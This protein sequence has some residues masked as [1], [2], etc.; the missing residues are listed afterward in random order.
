MGKHMKV[1]FDVD[2]PFAWAHGGVQVLV[3]ELM[4]HL[5]MVGVEVEPLKWWDPKQ[6]AD[7]INLFYH[8]DQKLIFAKEKGI[9]IANYVFLDNY[10]S[11]SR[12]DLYFR[13]KMIALLK[14]S[15]GNIDSVKGFSMKKYSDGFIFPSSNDKMLSHYLFGTDINKSFVILH[16]VADKYFCNSIQNPNKSDYLICISTIHKR[17]NSVMLAEIALSLKIPIYFLGR[18]YN[19]ED[20]Y[21]KRF[22]SIV[23]NKYVVYKG[24]VDE[25][26]K[27]K[28]M[29]NSKGFI[30]LS[31]SE[32]GCIAVLEA[33]AIKLPVFLPNYSWATSIYD[34][35]ATYGDMT[36][37][38]R[39]KS[40][41][42]TFYNAPP[43]LKKFKVS[44]W[45]EVSL[46][47]KQMYEQ[48]LSHKI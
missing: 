28:F 7:I 36:N 46:K 22:L 23:D 40:Q 1:L 35:S 47:Y 15:F 13:K 30:L 9:K 20:S 29:M 8:P 43:C 37:I 33:L 19:T 17:K 45:D 12:I 24:F 10:T 5:P 41:I 42:K 3:E 44:S 25:E 2:M 38:K 11:R 18:P 26:E 48:I 21:Y 34:S 39:L 6:K 32:S 31:K 4:K 14:Y 16:G 27:F